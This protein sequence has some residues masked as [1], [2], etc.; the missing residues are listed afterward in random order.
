MSAVKRQV[1]VSKVFRIR[2]VDGD[3]VAGASGWNPREESDVN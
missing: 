1:S 3:C 2:Q